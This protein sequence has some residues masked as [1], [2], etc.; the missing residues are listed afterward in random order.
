MESKLL[1]LALMHA[2]GIRTLYVAKAL[3]LIIPLSMHARDS[4]E[5]FAAMEV[6]PMW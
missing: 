2:E 1:R 5:E 3:L 6:A 4:R